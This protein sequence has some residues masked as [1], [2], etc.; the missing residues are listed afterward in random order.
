[1]NT[2]FVATGFDG[3]EQLLT[4]GQIN[5]QFCK[6]GK[7]LINWAFSNGYAAIDCRY[8]DGRRKDWLLRSEIKESK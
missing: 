5:A 1:M 6:T 7:K 2:I 3:T 8:M 4:L